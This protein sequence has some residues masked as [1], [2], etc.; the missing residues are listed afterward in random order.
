LVVGGSLWYRIAIISVNIPMLYLI[1]L[2][3]V[4]SIVRI[5]YEL[6]LVASIVRICYELELVMSIVRIGYGYS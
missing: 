3:F 1:E 4:V 2:V 6:E 5:G